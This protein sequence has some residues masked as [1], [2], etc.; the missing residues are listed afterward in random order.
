MQP[1]GGV[2]GGVPK[3]PS[4]VK[5]G[6]D[7]LDSAETCTRLLVHGDATGVIYD[8][9]GAVVVE[10]HLDAVAEP[11]ESLVDCVVDDLPQTVHQASGIRGADVHGGTFAHCLE[12]LKDQQVLRPV[13]TWGMGVGIRTHRDRLPGTLEER[14]TLKLT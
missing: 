13:I 7:H 10:G 14:A 11:R 8:L 5:P 4:R 12:A 3:L 9:Y 1:T 6:V 2:V